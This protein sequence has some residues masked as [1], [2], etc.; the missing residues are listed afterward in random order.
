MERAPLPKISLYCTKGGSDK[1]YHAEIKAKDDGYIVELR[2]GK[3]GAAKLQPGAPIVMS[4]DDANLKFEKIVKEKTS[5]KG[6]YTEELS[7]T[8]YSSS[9]LAG[10]MSGNNPHLLVA[11]SY[12]RMLE[13]LKDD[14]F[15]FETKI[16][17]E[18]LIVMSRDAKV[19][20]SNKLGKINSVQ[21][22]IIDELLLLRSDDFVIDG[23]W[24]DGKFYAFDI[25]R[26][27]G[28]CI[29]DM[30]AKDRHVILC[31][32]VKATTMP[33]LHTVPLAIG[34]EAKK[35]LLDHVLAN[36]GEGIVAKLL[37]A[38]YVEG[39]AAPK[40]ATQFKWVVV[41]NASFFIT[42]LHKTKRSAS[43][44]LLG[45]PGADHEVGNVTIPVNVGIPEVGDIID[46]RY[47]HLFLG[48]CLCQPVYVKA[49]TDVLKSDCKLTQITRFKVKTSETD[50]DEE[51]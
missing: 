33:H 19:V 31:E 39:K 15:G 41:E 49:R 27:N 6:G 37:S 30:P 23:E 26:I 5:A 35:A 29:K 18:R 51:E 38:P 40:E 1:E 4:L 14:D 8:G 45:S 44:A 10:Q 28:R 3:R 32:L 22:D 50:M 7:G 25:M 46:V 43:I 9:D 20:T 24:L 47:R 42:S 12:E 34:Y 13:L 17:G 11:I 16:D 2:N 48:G 21:Q 36:M